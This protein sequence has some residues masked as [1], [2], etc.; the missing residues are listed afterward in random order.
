MNIKTPSAEVL[1]ELRRRFAYDPNSGAVKR[2]SGPRHYF[3]DIVG[4]RAGQ[5]P[6]RDRYMKA[7]ITIGGKRHRIYVH[8]IAWFLHYGAW[9]P[10]GI[11]HVN[12]DGRDNR[13]VNLRLATKSQNAHNSDMLPHN[14][15]GYRG[16]S[17]DARG[18]VYRAMLTTTRDGKQVHYRLGGFD[19]AE[20][21]ASAYEH[22]ARRAQGAFFRPQP[23]SAALPPPPEKLFRGI[24]WRRLCADTEESGL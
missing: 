15:S 4:E 17:Y 24:A 18:R 19:S 9:P 11:D 22:A 21:A 10:R 14:T 12:G 6:G 5:P 16:V 7:H 1:S 8:H 20:L 13:L 2:V 3:G 23:Y